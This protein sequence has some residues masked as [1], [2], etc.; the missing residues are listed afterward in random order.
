MKLAFLMLIQ[1]HSMKSLKYLKWEK[2]DILSDFQ[3]F[4][5]LKDELPFTSWF[6]CLVSKSF[7]ASFDFDFPGAMESL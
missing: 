5:E 4:E 6:T 1:S 3:C 2:N 7:R